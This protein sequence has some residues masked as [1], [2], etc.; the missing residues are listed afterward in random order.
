MSI[1][2]P[3]LCQ[4]IGIFD[5]LGALLGEYSIQKI[6]CS[7]YYINPHV[8]YYLVVLQSVVKAEL[9]TSGVQY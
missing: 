5:G 7:A 1:Y 8:G 6:S 9:D 3:T 2:N 4:C